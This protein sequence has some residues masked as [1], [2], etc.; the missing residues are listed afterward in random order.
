M[1]LLVP[2][3]H[4]HRLIQYWLLVMI[5]MLLGCFDSAEAFTPWHAQ[6]ALESNRPMN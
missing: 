3:S 5:A 6:C 1:R 2:I 4:F